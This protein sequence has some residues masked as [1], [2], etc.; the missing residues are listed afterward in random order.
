MKIIAD[1]CANHIG[2]NKIMH[3]MILDA[4]DVGIDILKFQIFTANKLNE[5]WEEQYN[6]YKD[7]EMQKCTFDLII[8]TCKELGI[9]SLFTLF[10]PDKEDWLHDAGLTS[11][12][13]GSAEAHHK[14]FVLQMADNFHTVYLSCGMIDNDLIRE[15]RKIPNIK[16][17]YC[18][19]K[20][21]LTS[22]EIDFE[23][24]KHF[25]GFSDH[26][27]DLTASKRAME[28]GMDYIERHYTLGKFLPGKD[29]KLSSTP[30]EFQE[31]VNH[32][33]YV[34]GKKKFQNRWRF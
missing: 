27:I 17:F 30:D 13:I 1:V 20:Y 5:D 19:S 29:H 23:T 22:Y 11:V 15:Y 25:D 10:D 16:L 24:M 9:K 34:L 31:L 32:K 7:Y 33:N 3:K 8:K 14:D 4:K 28:L 18:V 26:T 12:K 21:P 2:N 6:Y